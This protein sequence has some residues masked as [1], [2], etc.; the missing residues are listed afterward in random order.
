MPVAGDRHPPSIGPK[1]VRSRTQNKY[2]APVA[3][4]NSEVGILDYHSRSIGVFDCDVGKLLELSRRDSESLADVA[5]R[6]AEI[7]AYWEPPE[8][9]FTSAPPGLNPHRLQ[10][11]E[12]LLGLV[13]PAQLPPKARWYRRHVRPCIT[14]TV[15]PPT[16]AAPTPKP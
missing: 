8:P 3:G 6:L 16:T 12:E 14:G 15:T 4:R 11:R 2:V 5:G 9:D 10:G 13:G 7:G 1:S